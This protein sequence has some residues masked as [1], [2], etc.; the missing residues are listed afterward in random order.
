MTNS[1]DVI[2]DLELSIAFCG[3]AV[4]VGYDRCTSIISLFTANIYDI[5]V[6]MACN[7]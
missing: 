7:I 4:G 3:D 1:W 6:M 2:P 5:N